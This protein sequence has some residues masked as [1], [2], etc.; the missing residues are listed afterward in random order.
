MDSLLNVFDF[1]QLNNTSREWLVLLAI[2][3][4]TIMAVMACGM[5]IF[6][7]HNS[8]KRRL[9]S[10]NGQ[11]SASS[12]ARY[13]PKVS[14]TLE[15]L[16]SYI[17]PTNEKE[18]EGVRHQLMHAGFYQKT[19]VANFYAIKLF[20]SLFFLFIAALVYI[21]MGGDVSIPT[22]LIAALAAGVFLPNIALNRLIKRRQRE[23]R[24]GIADM[25][26]LLVVCTES[27]LGFVASL[28]RVSDELYISHPELADELDTVC[29]KIKAGVEMPDAFHGLIT[30]TGLEEFRGL[31]AMLAHANKVGGS[32]AK[33][34]RD[35]ADDYRDKRNQAAEEI[36]AKIPTQML[37]PMLIFIWPCFFIVAVG[38]AILSLMAA[39][40]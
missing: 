40:K 37:F 18:K 29:V 16:S 35:Y 2:M 10:V 21:F 5:L 36:A 38:P 24:N 20:A 39:F 11:D 1:S 19:A 30:R 6:G 12:S 3:L 32:I 15:S 7:H 17:L 22:L 26:D 27:G 9:A 28:R 13:S 8:V 14:N 23:I 34:L 31:V 4:A 25:L 33:T